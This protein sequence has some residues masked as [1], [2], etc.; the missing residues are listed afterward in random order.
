VAE[1]LLSVDVDAPPPAVWA[2]LTD[3]AG[4]GEW[5]L[6]T[7]VRPTHQDGQGVGGRLAARTGL[8]PLSLVDTMTITTWEPPYRCLVRHTGRVVCGTGAFEVAELP[9]GRSRFTWTEW[10][11]LPLGRLGHLGFLLARPFLA[12]GVRLSLRRFARWVVRREAR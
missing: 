9:D 5:M 1:L 8:G 11:D 2:A 4:Q 10:L 7:T 12:A 6:A 3:W